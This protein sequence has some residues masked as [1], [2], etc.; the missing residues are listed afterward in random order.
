MPTRTLVPKFIAGMLLLSGVAQAQRL[1]ESQRLD[2]FNQLVAN[3]RAKYGPLVYKKETQNIDID[4]LYPKYVDIIKNGKTNGDFYYAINR[5]IAEFKDGHF[6]SMVPSTHQKSLGVQTDLVQGKVLIDTVDRNVHSQA[7]FPF[8]KGDE[9]VAVDNQ[10]TAQLLNSLKAY[11]YNANDLS[12]T[13][14][15]AMMFF[16]RRAAQVPVPTAKEVTVFVKRR[17]SENVDRITLAWRE[18]GEALDEAV[19]AQG[20]R[21]LFSDFDR[22]AARREGFADYQQLSLRSSLVQSLGRDRVE[23]S[24]QCSG[25]TR[26][27]I[28]EGATV[29]MQS[30]FVAYYWPTAEGNLGYL[31]IP[32]Y[33]PVND[34]T[35]AEEY[36]LRFQQYEYAVAELERNTVGLVIDQDHNCGGSVDY[37]E[38]MVG[39]FMN[40]DYLPLSFRFMAG[41][42]DL[43]EWKS[44]MDPSAKHT[45]DY[46][47]MQKVSDA[48]KA[49]WEN[50]Q[51]MTDLTS[52]NALTAIKPN[53]RVQYTKP[54]VMLIDENSGS[55]GD[56]F[57][58]M[59]KGYGRAKLVGTRTMGLGGHV[60]EQPALANSG[61]TYRMTRSL[62]YRP[63][64][65]AVENNGAIPDYPYEITADDFVNGYQGYRAFYTQ[66][67]LDAVKAVQ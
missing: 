23:R 10:T 13:R 5:F 62:F 18:S 36:V 35:G 55:G 59:L 26:I 16:V 64:G 58:S 19:S 66:K 1:T 67:L 39:L 57:P 15:A 2:D 6:G 48:I 53:A 20:M 11:V 65:V 3:M 52:F 25:G 54:I 22:P 17:G 29:I 51:R 32:H 30:P 28:P 34:V 46:V 24:Y 37:L 21:T 50:N 41:K 8:N 31:R 38:R 56:A 7:E 44:W 43:L 63:D 14:R 42:A 33:S 40:Q 12:I 61:M 47:L 27:K 45:I 60:T 9:I 49:A 4:V